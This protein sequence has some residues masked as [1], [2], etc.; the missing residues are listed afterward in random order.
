MCRLDLTKDYQSRPYPEIM[1]ISDLVPHSQSAVAQ[2]SLVKHKLTWLPAFAFALLSAALLAA[3]QAAD[4]MGE[5]AVIFPPFTSEITAWDR[6]RE[7]GGYV[8]GPTRFSN[9]VVVYTDDP[10]FKH[11]V[12]Q[13]G[14]LWFTQATG[15]CA[16][17]LT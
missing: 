9:I 7:A 12:S 6:V 17:A 13:L 14:A 3:P 10:A 8:V 15:L 4:D 2:L 11:R 1:T 5:M 16:E